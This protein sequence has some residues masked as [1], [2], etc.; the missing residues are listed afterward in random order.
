MRIEEKDFA[1]YFPKDN[2]FLHFCARYYGLSFFNNDVVE[3]AY[4][5]ALNNVLRM[6]N[7]QQEFEDEKEKNGMIMS[8]FRFG[9][10]AAYD[11]QK[12]RDRLPTKNES[13]LTY[14][15][16]DDE[17]NKFQA[18][19]T[20]SD[21]EYDNLYNVL[22]EFIETKLNPIEKIAIKEQVM[23]GESYHSVA[24]RHDIGVNAL[25]AGKARAIRKLKKYINAITSTEHTKDEAHRERRYVSSDRSK[26]Q[27][28][29]L[30][31]P[32]RQQQVEASRYSE[33]LSFLHLE[34]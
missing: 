17:Y 24:T 9:I 18:T 26:L 33:A 29:I 11:E 27:L 14:G 3:A 5:H 2:R 25:R 22:S 12:R 19:A 34:E 20:S 30:L 28:E 6:Y 31:E 16:G 10:L 4:S 15:S 21:R 13:Q 7:R 8:S 23:D 32:I 1:Q